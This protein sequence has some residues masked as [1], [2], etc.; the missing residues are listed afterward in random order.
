MA[1]IKN[2][3]KFDVG[4]QLAELRAEKGLTQH[5][6]AIK[7]GCT[8]PM[9]ANWEGGFNIPNFGYLEQLC[10]LYGVELKLVKRQKICTNSE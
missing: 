2:K 7:T 3:F 9:V 4:R 8:A 1:R 5:Q 10:D 6:V